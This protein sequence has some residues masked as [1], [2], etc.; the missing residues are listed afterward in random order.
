MVFASVSA[1]AGPGSFTWLTIRVMMIIIYIL[2]QSHMAAPWC[3]P[4][5]SPIPPSVLPCS[6]A[7]SPPR[8]LSA[9][10][11]VGDAGILVGSHG[12]FGFL[13]TQSPA[14]KTRPISQVSMGSQKHLKHFQMTS[15]TAKRVC[16]AVV[17]TT[18]PHIFNSKCYGL[19]G[20]S[21]DPW[22][23]LGNESRS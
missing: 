14:K 13:K 22:S 20:A 23:E 5:V 3:H 4:P 21:R 6:P 1:W 15:K 8:G 17:G 16:V 11:S 18:F 12:H 2:D 9:S 10:S 19:G 7:Q